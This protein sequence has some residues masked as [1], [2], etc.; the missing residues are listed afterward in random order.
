MT[1]AGIGAGALIA[2]LAGFIIMRRKSKSKMGVEQTATLAA[3]EPGRPQ[4]IEEMTKQIESKVKNQAVE[5][6][7]LE[8]EELMALKVPMVKTQKTEVLS[9]YIANEAKTDGQ[10]LAQVVRTWLNG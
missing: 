6:A 8:A 2:L 9:K 4:T 5:K 1:I 10:V 3:G 7:R